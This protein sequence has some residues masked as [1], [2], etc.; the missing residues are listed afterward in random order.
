MPK[1]NKTV[2]VVV[3]CLCLSDL[4]KYLLNILAAR[5]PGH[6]GAAVTPLHWLNYLLGHISGAPVTMHWFNY[7]LRHISGPLVHSSGQGGSSWTELHCAAAQFTALHSININSTLTYSSL[8]FKT[9]LNCTALY[10]RLHCNVL[11][12]N[13]NV[14]VTALHRS[15]QCHRGKTRSWMIFFCSQIICNYIIAYKIKQLYIFFF[16]QKLHNCHT[17]CKTNKTNYIIAIVIAKL[18]KPTT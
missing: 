16:Y 17:I 18:T 5:W 14:L 15:L 10:F 9:A 7:L 13:Y 4:A 12:T 3:A 6:S 8:L 2:R 11:V 1:S